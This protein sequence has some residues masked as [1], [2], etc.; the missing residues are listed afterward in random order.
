VIKQQEIVFSFQIP[1]SLSTLESPSTTMFT[2]LRQQI[3]SSQKSLVNGHVINKCCW[4]SLSTPQ[5]VH[6][7]E[8]NVEKHS[9]LSIYQEFYTE[10]PSILSR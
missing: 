9:L 1:K 5:N 7:G 3:K 8:A 10:S 2:F 4:D 6:H